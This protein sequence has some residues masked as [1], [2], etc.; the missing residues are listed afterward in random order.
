M[1]YDSEGGKGKRIVEFDFNNIFNNSCGEGSLFWF[2]FR[3]PVGLIPWI[4]RD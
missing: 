1:N 2:P 4:L 3:I